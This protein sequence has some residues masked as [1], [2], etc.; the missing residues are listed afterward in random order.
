MKVFSTVDPFRSNNHDEK[1][2]MEER[3]S[4]GGASECRE[5]GRP[6]ME[7]VREWRFVIFRKLVRRVELVVVVVVVVLMDIVVGSAGVSVVRRARLVMAR[8]P[9]VKKSE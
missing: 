5:G 2:A 4:L 9:E 1:E 8:K 3:L 7:V 6:I